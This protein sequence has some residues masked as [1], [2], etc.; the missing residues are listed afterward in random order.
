[1]TGIGTTGIGAIGAANLISSATTQAAFAAGSGSQGVHRH[2]QHTTSTSAADPDSDG[3]TGS[4]APSGNSAASAL[5][6]T[7]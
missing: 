7:A 1:M 3:D 6:T 2:H 5:D 4:A